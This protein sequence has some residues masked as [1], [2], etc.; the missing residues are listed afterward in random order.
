[1]KCK[2]YFLRSDASHDRQLTDQLYIVRNGLSNL[3]NMYKDNVQEF[4][5]AQDQYLR[6][7]TKL[8]VDRN[9]LGRS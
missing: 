9:F 2:G 4:L 7:S 1:M 5:E 6:K 8:E 3:R